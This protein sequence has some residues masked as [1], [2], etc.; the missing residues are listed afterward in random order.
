MGYAHNAS[1]FTRDAIEAVGRYTAISVGY[2][3]A[4]D[5]ALWSRFADA[6]D[7]NRGHNALT[8]AEWFYIYRW[9]VSPGH[10]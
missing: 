3:A 8:R 7:P 10:V 4:I 9:G 6:A 2:D 1:L 5:A